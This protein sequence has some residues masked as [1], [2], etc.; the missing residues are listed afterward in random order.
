MESPEILPIEMRYREGWY[1]G[2]L[3]FWNE[4][5]DKVQVDYKDD[6]INTKKSK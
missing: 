6:K 5:K 3:N 4:I 2:V 1:D